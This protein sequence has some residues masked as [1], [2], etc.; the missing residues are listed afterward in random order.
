[1]IV[2]GFLGY[3][4]DRLAVLRRRV[5]ASLAEASTVRCA[6]PLAAE[7]MRLWHRAVTTVE[8]WDAR[9]AAIQ[10]CG[11]ASPYQP[12]AP[13]AGWPIDVIRP[14][15]PAW[16][17]ATDPL[18]GP[19]ATVDPLERVEQLIALLAGLDPALLGSAASLRRLL[20]LL[21][22]TFADEAAR[23]RWF[24]ALGPGGTAAMVASLAR[25]VAI[26]P[27]TDPVAAGAEAVLSRVAGGLGL[28]VRHGE[29][30]EAAYRR[31]ALDGAWGDTYA[32]AL[33][34]RHAA[35]PSAVTT[36]WARDVVSR[37]RPRDPAGLD[38]QVEAGQPH[39]GELVLAALTADPVAGRQVLRELEELDVVL[40][41]HLDGDARGRFLLAAVDPTRFPADETVGLL[42]HVLGY[43]DT[44][45]NVAA[46]APNAR[47]LHDW[48][49]AC[50]FP[51][52]TQLVPSP[53][54]AVAGWGSTDV[55]G[56]MVWVSTS[57]LSAATLE[58]TVQ[59]LAN[60]VIPAA[61]A[62]A[63]TGMAGSHA[64]AAME[65]LGVIHA[66]IE[67]GQALWARVAH[68]NYET[69]KFVVGTL[70]SKVLTLP[71]GPLSV[72]ASIAVKEGVNLLTSKLVEAAF[73]ELEE[74]GIAH[75]P[76]TEE[77]MTEIMARR[78]DQLAVAAWRAGVGAAA[79]TLVAAGTLRPGSPPP[80]PRLIE[81]EESY[82]EQLGGWAIGAGRPAKHVVQ[83]A[84]AAAAG[85]QAGR[86]TVPGPTPLGPLDRFDRDGV[87]D[88]SRGMVRRTDKAL[89][90]G[91]GAVIS[92]P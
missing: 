50:I 87:I 56:L 73:D 90:A 33:V 78:S 57:P 59:R 9:L 38:T 51:Y 35:F 81:N 2:S 64:H 24:E 41:P 18:T 83:V 68:R 84:D 25:W 21:D 63:S 34:L 3:D 75:K 14:L 71:A 6:D 42:Q 29:V 7:P 53:S 85:Y 22:A 49:G 79:T 54:V 43:L 31:A 17:V 74:E 80:E 89:R 26:G 77:E 37:E 47:D 67:R 44:H 39:A 28:A 12:V 72:L 32:A 61:L 91:A 46:G 4:P 20:D 16:R 8:P 55:A 48:L 23:C 13:S 62:T 11:F 88:L 19:A 45:R 1:M 76:P 66:T 86:A 30:D 36:A 10:N 27:P 52:L 5:A 15:T 70:I 82:R 60:A 40:G 69:G 92:A 65:Q 58:A